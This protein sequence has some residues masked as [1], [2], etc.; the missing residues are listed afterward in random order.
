MSQNIAQS[1]HI[2][3]EDHK[4]KNSPV[5]STGASDL[6]IRGSNPSSAKTSQDILGDFFPSSSDPHLW[7]SLS[8]FTRTSRK[9]SLKL[10]DAW[11]L[12]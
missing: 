11:M 12:W 7:K 9:M 6:G 2:S 8:Y 3:G 10:W 4:K 5:A 1:N